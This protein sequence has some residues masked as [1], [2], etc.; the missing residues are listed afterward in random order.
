VVLDDYYNP[1]WPGV[2]EGFVRYMMY[3]NCRLAPFLYHQNKLYLAAYSFHGIY[4]DRVA[5]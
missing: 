5:R 3:G 4:L 1:H 2:H